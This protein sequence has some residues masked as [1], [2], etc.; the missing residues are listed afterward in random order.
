MEKL[1]KLL[2]LFEFK[3]YMRLNRYSI[4]YRLAILLLTFLNISISVI[5]V[6]IAL[7]TKNLIDAAVNKE[8]NVAFK[9]GILF[10]LL[11]V[12]DLLVGSYLSY[13]RVKLKNTMLNKMQL[14][15]LR[16]TYNKKWL[17]LN[18]YKTGDLLTRLYDDIE[19]IVYSLTTIIPTLIAMFL[20]LVM[21]F[22]ILAYYDPLLAV[23]TFLV[24][25]I[26]ILFSMIIGRKL[27]EIQYNVQ[28]TASEQRS[29]INESLQNLI[30]LKTYNFL[31]HNIEL[32]R[33]LQN[34]RFALLRR[35]NIIG[36]KANILIEVGYSIAFFCTLAFGAYRLS[37]GLITFGTFAAFLQLI[38]E[39]Q[40]PISEMASSLPMLI[41][42][43]SSMDRIVELQDSKTDGHQLIVGPSKL[44]KDLSITGLSF[45]Y[46][47]TTPILNRIDFS[48]KRGD[49]IGIIGK[50]GKGKTTFLHILLS[51]VDAEEGDILITELDGNKVNNLNVLKNEFAYVSQGNT[52]FSGSIRDNLFI[53]DTFTKERIDL[54]LQVAQIKSFVDSLENGLDTYIHEKGNDLSQGQAQ[55]LCI[56]RA[57]VQERQFLILDEATSALDNET[58]EAFIREL[59]G[60]YKDMT[61]IAVTHRK[62]ILSICNK[63]YKLDNKKMVLIE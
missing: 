44:I 53:E 33:G 38:E 42:S 28:A 19:Q 8:L 55:R 43:L 59:E 24:T 32:V 3:T 14:D 4:G 54:A 6:A 50:S 40:T 63:I 35:K 27:K 30:I 39:I 52:L 21:A 34:K 57:L 16:T 46:Q 11:L 47:P 58:E 29:L 5:S 13:Y 45:A 23:L 9:F 1:S 31:N 51:L 62:N 15:L 41:S 17:K 60:S 61:I 36:I 18:E 12:I 37:F 49:H 26:T 7:I 20:Q 56:A 22:S 48:L 10:A 2:V 25:P